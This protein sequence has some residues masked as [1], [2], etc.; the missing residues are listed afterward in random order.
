MVKQGRVCSASHGAGVVS[1]TATK[2]DMFDFGLGVWSNEL[3]D[4]GSTRVVLPGSVRRDD[5]V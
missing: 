3:F 1:Q 5:K 2:G 4:S